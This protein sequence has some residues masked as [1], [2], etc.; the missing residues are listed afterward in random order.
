MKNKPKL[1]D[2]VIPLQ[3]IKDRSEFSS[4]GTCKCG[5]TLSMTN[6]YKLEKDPMLAEAKMICGGCQTIYRFIIVEQT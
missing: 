6:L 5:R 3:L 2:N 4:I 1:D